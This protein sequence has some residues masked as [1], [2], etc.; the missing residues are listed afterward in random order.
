LKIGDKPGL[1]LCV[2][3]DK[4]AGKSH[5]LA[6]LYMHLMRISRT[7][8]SLGSISTDEEFNGGV[9]IRD[10]FDKLRNGKPTTP[11][12]A[13]DTSH[14]TMRIP[15]YPAGIQKYLRLLWIGRVKNIDLHLLDSSGEYQ[16]YLMST[17]QINVD[18][19]FK[20]SQ[21]SDEHVSIDFET[22][23]QIEFDRK[24]ASMSDDERESINDQFKEILGA[25]DAYIL[26]Y[27]IIE[28]RNDIQSRESIDLKLTRF[29]DNVKRYRDATN[30]RLPRHIML[31]FTKYDL[32]STEKFEYLGIPKIDE[33]DGMECGLLLSQLTYNTIEVMTGRGDPPTIISYTDMESNGQNFKTELDPESG[34]IVTKYPYEAYSKVVRWIKDIG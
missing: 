24:T 15:V 17:A 32:V 25:Y 21:S 14:V 29:L 16:Q 7:D 33:L 6:T 31:A 10:N 34:G 9:G 2:I 22:P 30:K 5:F 12:T 4:G 3:G 27:P 8:D 26:L 11:M 1:K 19:Q 20:S 13:G 23:T 18:G 28:Y